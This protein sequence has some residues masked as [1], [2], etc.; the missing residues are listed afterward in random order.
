MRAEPRIPGEPGVWL[1][2]FGEMTVFAALFA[3]FLHARH[4][5]VAGFVAGV[6][7]VLIAG[8]ACSACLYTS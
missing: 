6:A 2:I 5:D 3:S 7:G 4:G 8:V 1:L